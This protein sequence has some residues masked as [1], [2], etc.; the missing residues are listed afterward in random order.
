M[1]VIIDDEHICV[2]PDTSIRM[3]IYVSSYRLYVTYV[4]VSSYRLYVCM[5][6]ELRILEKTEF[7][8]PFFLESGASDALMRQICWPLVF[9][10]CDAMYLIYC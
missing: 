7:F 4:Y 10:F 3:Y 8:Y 2:C 6:L 1:C 5:G 9:G